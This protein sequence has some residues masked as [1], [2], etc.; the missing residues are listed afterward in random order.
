MW[1][2][3]WERVGE[4]AEDAGVPGDQRVWAGRIWCDAC[5][6]DDD[7]MRK[8]E[9]VKECCGKSSGEQGERQGQRR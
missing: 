7:H 2:Q 9:Y 1:G 8:T 3:S 6:K 4:P 5:S